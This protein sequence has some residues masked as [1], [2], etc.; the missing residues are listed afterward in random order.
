MLAKQNCGE[1]T[2]PTYRWDLK[3]RRKSSA[4]LPSPE[5]LLMSSP[6]AFYVNWLWN[7]TYEWGPVRQVLPTPHVLFPI[8]N[9]YCV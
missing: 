9:Y 1:R 5:A 3:R 8:A 6:S 2:V 4:L 7:Q